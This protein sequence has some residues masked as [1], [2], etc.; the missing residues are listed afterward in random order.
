MAHLRRFAAPAAWARRGVWQSS[1]GL[2]RQPSPHRLQAR[3]SVITPCRGMSCGRGWMVC[4]LRHGV[5]HAQNLEASA[6]RF[7]LRQRAIEISAAVPQ[8]IAAAR[9]SPRP[10]RPAAA[11]CTGA[12]SAGTGMFQKPFLHGAAR[13]PA[14]KYQRCALLH[15]H[16]KHADK[17]LLVQRTQPGAKI[18][19][20]AQ[21][22]VRA[23]HR[24]GQQPACRAPG[25]IQQRG[26]AAPRPAAAA[27]RACA[28]A[29]R[30]GAAARPG[31]IP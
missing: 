23:D 29:P 16:R 3:S 5:A 7:Q 20:A 11:A 24:A 19:F 17:T 13:R 15:H 6:L 30:S 28:G 25:G 14:A 31:A 12:G 8:S 26:D 2:V 27:P 22:P 10:A 1:S 4:Q 18:R 21:R 9:R